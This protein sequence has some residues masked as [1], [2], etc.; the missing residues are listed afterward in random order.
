MTVN[1][2]VQKKAYTIDLQNIGMK[3]GR[4]CNN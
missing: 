4:L 2:E 1:D 3:S